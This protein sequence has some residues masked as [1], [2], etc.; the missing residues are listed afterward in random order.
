MS[1]TFDAAGDLAAIV[2]QLEEVTFRRRGKSG[3]TV[4][5][6]A[7]RRRVQLREARPSA[8]A[9]TKSE[10]VWHLPVGELLVTPRLGDT[11]VDAQDQTWTILDIERTEALGNW[12]LL[13]RNLAVAAGLDQLV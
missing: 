1:M 11:I 4:I 13:C 9:V 3:A 8:G 6:H 12:R 7:L 10:T 5:P 2:D